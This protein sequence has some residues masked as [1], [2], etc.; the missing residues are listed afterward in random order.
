MIPGREW[1]HC[2]FEK[3]RYTWQSSNHWYSR[4]LDIHSSDGFM[5]EGMPGFSPEHASKYLLGQ[6]GDRWLYFPDQIHE[7]PRS[8]RWCFPRT[9]VLQDET[10]VSTTGS[11]RRG[12][13]TW[14]RLGVCEAACSSF[15][16]SF[17]LEQDPGGI[18]VKNFFA[19]TAGLSEVW[20]KHGWRC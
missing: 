17:Q 4:R 19:F 9:R 11:C 1:S 18:P 15:N 16:E 7:V 20:S 8:L 13:V 3:G 6:L 2:Y 10:W 5:A 14:N 12:S